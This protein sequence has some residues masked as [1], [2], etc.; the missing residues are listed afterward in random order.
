[1]RE[2]SCFGLCTLDQLTSPRLISSSGSGH[3]RKSRESFH[4]QEQSWKP[5]SNDTT[6]SL[7]SIRKPSSPSSNPVA[8]FWGGPYPNKPTINEFIPLSVEVG[9]GDLN[10]F[11][12]PCTVFQGV[13]AIYA[14]AKFWSPFFNTAWVAE[15]QPGWIINIICYHVEFQQG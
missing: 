5:G 10:H 9:C 15:L 8:A 11:S 6:P 7:Q 1:M 14:V 3:D 12:T 4:S 13:N 2:D